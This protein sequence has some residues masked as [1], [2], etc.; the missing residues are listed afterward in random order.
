MIYIFSI[1]QEYILYPAKKGIYFYI[2]VTI[3]EYMINFFVIF[4]TFFETHERIFVTIFFE[5]FQHF[6]YTMVTNFVQLCPT[7]MLQSFRIV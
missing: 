6:F 3:F 2:C 5:C 1:H 7:L 4:S